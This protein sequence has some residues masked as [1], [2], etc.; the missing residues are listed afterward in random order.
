MDDFLVCFNWV[1]DSEDPLRRYKAVPDA[2]PGAF[3]I[4]G[5]NSAKF[6][7]DFA[8]ITELPPAE[9]PAAVEAF[10]RDKFWNQWL[11]E[12]LSIDVKKRVMDACFNQG[13]GTGVR[14]LQEA[15]NE[16]QKSLI[17]TDGEWG[18]ITLAAA[19][20]CGSGALVAAF[21]AAREEL[22]RRIAAANPALEADLPGWLARARK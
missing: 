10:Y 13:P 18:P 22:Y 15:V 6:P 20:A 12:L 11:A 2:P 3:V 7:E 9:R 8:R 21:C 1:M 4:S 19:N 17:E 14:L 5:I 16:T